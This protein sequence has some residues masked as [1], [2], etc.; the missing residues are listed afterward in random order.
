MRALN[1]LSM[2]LIVGCTSGEPLTAPYG[3]TVSL[4]PTTITASALLYCNESG[5]EPD[6]TGGMAIVDVLVL[7]DDDEPLERIEVEIEVASIGGIYVIPQEAVKTVDLPAADADIETEAD[8]REACTDDDGNYDNSN[9][10]CAWYW[11]ESNA[12]YY[13]FGEDYADAGGYAPTYF[14]GITNNRGLAQFYTFF[15]CIYG[16]S[17]IYASIGVDSDTLTISAEDG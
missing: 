2:A 1:P 3:A 12:Q 13:Q 4:D 9:E 15:D 16:D 10:W 11:D 8:I 17:Y 7:S 6:Y 14:Y 5:A